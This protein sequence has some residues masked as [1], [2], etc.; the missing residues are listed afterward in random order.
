[1]PSDF[2]GR[3]RL[4]FRNFFGATI[5]LAVVFICATYVTSDVLTLGYAMMVP[6]FAYLSFLIEDARIEK[7]S[8]RGFEVWIEIAI[9]AAGAAV[10]GYLGYRLWLL[11][12]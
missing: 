2:T 6:V 11:G 12:F 9:A 8:P 10:V 5:I 3:Y 7:R 4:R 1:M